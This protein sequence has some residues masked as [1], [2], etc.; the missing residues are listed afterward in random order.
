[1]RFAANG[2]GAGW[3]TM[4]PGCVLAGIGVGLINTPVA[5]TAAAA[6]PAE[7][8]GMASGMDMSVRMIVLA[9]SIAVMGFVLLYGIRG[10]FGPDQV[11]EPHFTAIAEAIAAGNFKV[12]EGAGIGEPAARQALANGFTWVMLYGALCAWAL[13]TLSVI[14]LSGRKLAAA[15]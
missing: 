12:G 11:A 15:R 14:V 6:V 10:G 2:D 9:I 7:R 3:I 5:N 8:A 1:M 13:A 4:L